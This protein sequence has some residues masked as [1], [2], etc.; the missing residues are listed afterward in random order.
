MVAPG[1]L[2][3]TKIRAMSEIDRGSPVAPYRQV[4]AILIARIRRGEYGPAQQLPSVNELMATYGIAKLTAQKSLWALIDEGYAEM[5]RGMGTFVRADFP[6]GPEG[7][8]G[9]HHGDST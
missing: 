5:S 4:Q 7:T 9:A 1:H 2:A 8:P 3:G 6:R